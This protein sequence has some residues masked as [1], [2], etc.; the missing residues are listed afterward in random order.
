MTI[1][2]PVVTLVGEHV[3]GDLLASLESLPFDLRRS[4]SFDRARAD[5]DAEHPAVIV[6]PSDAVTSSAPPAG[7]AVGTDAVHALL[8]YGRDAGDLAGRSWE[9]V[10]DFLLP[11]FDAELVHL[12]LASLLERL[13][14]RVLRAEETERDELL[15]LERD[16]QIGH[17]IQLGFLPSV[18]PQPEGWEITAFF[19]PAREVAGDF[20]DAF[21][22]VN[23]RR[24]GFVIADVC[25]KGVGAA[26]FMSLFR[27]LVR[28][29]AQHNTS[30]SWM[31]PS[32]GS[33]TEDKDWLSGDPAQRRQSLPTI[34]TGPLLNAVVSTND[35]IT[36]NHMEQ[37]YFAT[38]FVGL[39]DPSNGSL[40]YINGGHNPPVLQRVDGSRDL[41][42]PT[43]PAVGM[44]P[45]VKFKLGQARIGPGDVLFAYTDG[46]P[47]ARAPGGAFFTED[48]MLELVAEG[49]P[50][51]QELLDL[52]AGR[53][54]D[55][56]ASAPQF[57]DITMMAL[58]RRPL[59]AAGS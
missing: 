12:R 58:R 11:P 53:L 55:H 23:G 26:L 36:E 44:L 13:Q 15:K 52:V 9:G 50:T 21:S 5:L 33:V 42:R 27:T 4:P 14:Q 37:G 35:Y 56:I 3:D 25:D 8:V 30:L 57:D 31:D 46:V 54:R 59:D 29:N 40:V 16:L 7:G 48:R 28:S 39:L 47:E 18:L 43:G 32:S 49:A 2:A 10:S 1:G 17:D 34:G 45:G 38:M 22:M 51:A 20:Y 41:L 24:V 6:A 19:H